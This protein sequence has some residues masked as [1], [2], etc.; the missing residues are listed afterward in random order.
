[1]RIIAIVV[2][3]NRSK[4]L[5]RCLNALKNQSLKPDSILVVNN[6]ST[7][8]TE[9][10]IH[11]HNVHHLK[12]SNL[13]SAGGWHAGIDFCIKKNFEA[14]WLMDD[15]GYP[16]INA[17]K[18]LKENLHSTDSCI[19]S[20]VLKE[21]SKTEFVFPVPKLNTFHNPI[22]F[23]FKRKYLNIDEIKRAGITD[24]NFAHLFNGSLILSESIKTIGNVNK[25]YFIMGDEVDYFYRL[26]KVGNVRTIFKAMHF[27]PDVSKR[28]Y[29][30]IKIYYLIKNTIINHNKYFDQKILRNISMIIILLLR[31]FKRNGKLYLFKLIFNKKLLLLKATYLG[32]RGKLGTD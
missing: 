3:H 32:F 20:C 26:R 29:S 17:L 27:H 31:V 2:T 12:Q 7:D 4:L 19:S 8:N 1:M 28:K 25:D 6:G 5:N 30:D 14:C 16:D 11:K 15:D 24:Y 22:L 23:A 21:D 18:N 9:E 13:G 10:I